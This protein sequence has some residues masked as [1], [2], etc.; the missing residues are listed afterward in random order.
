MSALFAAVFSASLLGSAH[1]AGMCG[2]IVAFL[3][4]SGAD[5]SVAT[6]RRAAFAYHGGRLLGYAALGALAGLLGRALDLGGEALGIGRA[7]VLAAGALMLGYGLLQWARLRGVRVD[8]PRPRALEAL[9]KRGFGAVSRRGAVVR[10][11][12]IGALTA[13]L[14]CGWLYLFAATAA[15]TGSAVQGALVM[16]AFWAGTV[17]ALALVGLGAGR[18]AGPLARRAPAFSAT[19]LVLLGLWALGGRLT[20]PSFAA[21][22][23]DGVDGPACCEPEAR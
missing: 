13:L 12:V 5:A 17:P 11:L 22:A 1:C 16:A 18:L 3:A 2:G 20:P 15:G 6:R 7:A 9:W 21:A 14:P 23:Q 8:L 19:L 4:G 10:A